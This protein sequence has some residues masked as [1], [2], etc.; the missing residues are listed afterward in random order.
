MKVVKWILIAAVAYL[1]LVILVETWLG[2]FQPT[3]ARSGFPMLVITIMDESGESRDR[4]LARMESG[5]KIYVSA[6]HWPRAWYR[7]ALENPEVRAIIN[8]VTGDYIAVPV[9][10]EEYAQVVVDWP[11]PFRM[12]FLMGFAPRSL[13]RLDP[14]FLR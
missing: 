4:R 9:E 6:H 13:L 2:V 10:G 14:K 8:G 3:L 7:Q 5:G 12:R 1:G 11:I